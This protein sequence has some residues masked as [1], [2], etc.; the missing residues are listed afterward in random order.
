MKRNSSLLNNK[1]NYQRLIAVLA[2]AASS[3]LASIQAF[4]Q[5]EEIVV[6]AERKQ[7]SLQSTPIAITALTQDDLDRLQIASV[8][9]I[10]MTVP[11]LRI[12][13]NPASPNAINIVMRATS[14]SNAAFAF[15]E[16][17]VGFYQNGVYRRQS[18]GNLELADIERIEVLRGPQGTLFGRNTLA[19]AINIVTRVPSQESYGDVSVSYDSFDTAKIRAV[20]GGGIT[21]NLAGSVAV[22]FKDR[23][24][25]PHLNQFN[26]EKIGEQTFAGFQG[27][28]NWDATDNLN[29]FVSMYL[30]D[31]DGDGAFGSP[32]NVATEQFV[33]DLPDV[34]SASPLGQPDL[35]SDAGSKISGIDAIAS[36]QIS[37]SLEFKSISSY[38][39]TDTFWATDFSAGGGASGFCSGSDCIAGFFRDSDSTQDQYS[40]EVQLLGETDRFDW[41]LGAYYYQEETDQLLQDYFFFGA[42]APAFHLLKSDSKAI[43]GQTGFAINDQFSITV[44]ARYTED[45]KDFSGNKAN[46]FFA[47]Q[48]FASDTSIDE[49]TGKL[50][51]DYQVSDNLLV[52]GSYSEGFKSGAFDAF[53]AADTIAIPLAPELVDTIELGLKTDIFDDR[54]RI[55][56]A[57]SES[58]YTDFIVTSVAAAG[59]DSANGGEVDIPGLELEATWLPSDNLS[60]FLSLTRL[61]DNG[62]DETGGVEVSGI[63]VGD[64]VPFVSET[65]WSLGAS[66]LLPL[67]NGNELSFNIMGKYDSEYYPQAAHQRNSIQ[68]VEERYIVN[69]GLVY[70]IDDGK[71]RVWLNARNLTDENDYFSVLNFST[72]LF[73]NT[74][75]Y[76]PTEPR[77]FEVGYKYTF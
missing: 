3:L 1:T 58:Q 43:F 49:F 72:F 54:L 18:A 16:P 74:A 4:A 7:T 64:E 77:S 42:A 67:S 61:F 32:V 5:L 34:L 38:S 24:E 13:A 21:A 53:A 47:P 26:G 59:L 68:L 41:I 75:S 66:Y 23:S 35:S 39:S 48:D 62:W 36:W 14:E 8:D 46:V 37:D 6:T 10:D 44:G 15:S 73:N 45:S 12:D 76:L 17:K 29:V 57:L 9:D 65:Q 69:A 27:N 52:Y 60:L 56:A 31:D 11:G 2:L 51:L 30:S 25:G 63:R 50:G 70:E 22:L 55:N 33:F 71:H 28:L 40:Q 20:F 19:G